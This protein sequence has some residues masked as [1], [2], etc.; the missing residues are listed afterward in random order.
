MRKIFGMSNQPSNLEQE[1]FYGRRHGKKIKGTRVFLAEQ[2][3]PKVALS[4]PDK[5]TP[6]ETYFPSKPQKLY[7]EIGF[8]GGEHLAGQAFKHP[9]IGF[10]GAEPFLNGVVSLLAHL[11]GSWGKAANT[12]RLWKEGQADNVRIFADDVRLILPFWPD[13]SFDKIFVLYPDPWPKTRHEDRRFVGQKNLKELY[14]LL[15]KDGELRIATD[16]EDYATWA[17]EQVTLSQLFI[18]K[19]KNVRQPPT[20][21]ISTRYEQKGLSAGRHPT[22]LTYIPKK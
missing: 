16:V 6:P 20:D 10:I 15:K 1:R 3:L 19:N 7:L 4:V 22:Y 17:Q 12:D 2:F 13:N 9:D 5:I 8:G 14:R 11:N 21:W 18:Q